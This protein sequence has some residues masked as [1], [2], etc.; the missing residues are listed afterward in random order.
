MAYSLNMNTSKYEI[1]KVSL[2]TGQ[3]E[4]TFSWG[5]SPE[6]AIRTALLRVD[7]TTG[8]TEKVICVKL[9]E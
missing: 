7:E 9:A 4:I 1:T 8:E 6:E 5:T 2:L 3:P